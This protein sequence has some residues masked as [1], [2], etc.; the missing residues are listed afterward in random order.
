MHIFGYIHGHRFHTESIFKIKL[1]K[2]SKILFRTKSIVI[3]IYTILVECQ[4]AVYSLCHIGD[5]SKS[6]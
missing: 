4:S 6:G 1:R 2:S 3:F 5:V